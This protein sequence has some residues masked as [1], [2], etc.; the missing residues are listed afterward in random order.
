MEFWDINLTKDLS[1]LLHA[2]HSFGTG[3]FLKKT[4]LFCGFKSTVHT[5]K[6]AK[7]ENSSLFVIK[8]TILFCGFKSTVHTKKSA[9]HENSSLFVNSILQKQ[10]RVET[11]ARNCDLKCRSRIHSQMMVFPFAESFKKYF[12]S[13]GKP[14]LFFF[15]QTDPMAF[16]IFLRR[17]TIKFI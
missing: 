2:I 11:Q 13:D 17:K 4:I 16:A 9:K 10:K 12:I 7:H 8:K 1:L 6:S 14:G 5:K 15:L 3:G